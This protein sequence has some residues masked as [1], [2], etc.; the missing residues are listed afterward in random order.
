MRYSEFYKKIH[1]LKYDI[2]EDRISIYVRGKYGDAVVINKHFEN[3][4]C[5][6][7]TNLANCDG[8]YNANKNELIDICIEF[9]KT[10]VLE[11]EDKK[12]VK[13]GVSIEAKTCIEVEEDIEE[14]ELKKMVEN[15]YKYLIYDRDTYKLMSYMKE[16]E[17]EK[18]EA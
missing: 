9:A 4:I 2:Y 17:Y 10:P 3:S 8:F 16:E 18:D 5:I 7:G 13:I 14:E 11:R 15:S 1:E 12:K 6:Y